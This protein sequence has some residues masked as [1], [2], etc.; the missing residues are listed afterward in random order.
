MSTFLQ[1]KYTIWYFQIINRRLLLIPLNGYIERHHI[2]P[3]SLG[4]NNSKSNIVKLSAR[5][6]FICHWL[7]TKM[8]S[9][10]NRIKMVRA[11][12]AFKMSSRKNPRNLTARQYQIA[13]N[14]VPISW[15]KGKTIE[16]YTPK[17]KEALRK[18][19]LTKRGRTQTPEANAKRSETLKGRTFTPEHLQKISKTLKGRVSPTK[20]MKFE[21]K[22]CP[23][24]SCPHCDRIIGTNNIVRHIQARH[25]SD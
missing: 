17:Q 18:S 25:S 5:E 15:N 4:G 10:D 2:I 24:T 1:N 8:I 14:H 11:F 23:T 12:N 19:G 7:L 6:H 20:G 21:Y 9:G 22:P 13:R 16:D 3:K